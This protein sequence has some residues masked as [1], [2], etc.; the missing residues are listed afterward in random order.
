MKC[1]S[2]RLP[3]VLT[4]PVFNRV[5]WCSHLS[6]SPLLLSPLL[7]FQERARGVTSLLYPPMARPSTS[8]LCWGIPPWFL[9]LLLAVLPAGPL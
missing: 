5:E 8:A 2:V 1:S 9:V 7:C 6:H 4:R 3:F